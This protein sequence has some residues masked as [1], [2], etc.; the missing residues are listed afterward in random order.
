MTTVPDGLDELNF[1]SFI[2]LANARLAAQ[3]FA[4]PMA[5]EVLLTL[6][7][8]SSVVTYDLESSIHR[9]KGWSWAQFRLMYVTWLAGPVE[10]KLAAEL[11]GMSRAAVSN[12]TKP[13]VTDGYLDRTPDPADGRSV[14][15]S[16]TERGTARMVETFG[17]QNEREH[18]WVSVLTEAEQR[19]LILL[20]NKLITD[21]HQFDVRAR[22]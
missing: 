17:E 22:S 10:S 6:N 9:P 20:L 4:H 15:L 1:W 8:A 11:S 2:E 5:T 21:R 7:R 13:L 18:A 14:R 12:L 19:I 3:G 16:L